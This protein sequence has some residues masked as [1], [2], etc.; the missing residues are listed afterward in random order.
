MNEE[1]AK[2]AKRILD[3]KL[4]HVY[5]VE[6]EQL[7]RITGIENEYKSDLKAIEKDINQRNFSNLDKNGKIL[8]VAGNGKSRK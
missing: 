3:A 6:E 2:T 1:S 7:I 8:H 4:S 5:K